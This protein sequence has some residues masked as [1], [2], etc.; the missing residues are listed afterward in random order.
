ME[1]GV[2]LQMLLALLVAV[3]IRLVISI[4]VILCGCETWSLTLREQHTQRVSEGNI[5]VAEGEIGGNC[6]MRPDIVG[7]IKCNRI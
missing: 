7:A 3:A 6:I 5:S 4:F 2:T 1:G